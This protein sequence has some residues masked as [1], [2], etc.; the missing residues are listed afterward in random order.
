MYHDRNG[1]PIASGVAQGQAS[2]ERYTAGVYVKNVLKEYDIEYEAEAAYQFG[3]RANGTAARSDIKGLLL[4]GYAGYT[5]KTATAGLGFDFYTGNDAATTEREDF[6]H[7]FFTI[8][9]F[10][11]FMDFLPFTIVPSSGQRQPLNAIAG[12]GLINP[13]IRAT[14]QAADNIKLN[15]WTHYFRSQQAISWDGQQL[16]DIGIET[17]VVADVRI[18]KFVSAQ[19]GASVFLPGDAVKTTNA[20][21]GYGDKP[22]YWAYSMLTVK[23]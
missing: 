21:A 18:N 17:D 10:Y 13:Y 8:H 9:K 2:L 11:G 3:Q 1:A 15:F 6:D 20:A 22:A 16:Y 12:K 19:L 7:L 23:F 14:W 5:S 4:T